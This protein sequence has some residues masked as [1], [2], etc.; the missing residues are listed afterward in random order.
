MVKF[1]I[2]KY[3]EIMNKILKK[4]INIR[5]VNGA[6]EITTPFLDRHNDHI[7]IYVIPLAENKYLLTD[8]GNTARDLRTVD[9]S[10][11]RRYGVQLQGNEL[12]VTAGIGDFLQKKYNLIHAIITLNNKMSSGRKRR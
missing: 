1:L 11:L 9:K 2:I 3:N 8:D 4:G 12:T 5:E 7:Q 6:Y 10:V